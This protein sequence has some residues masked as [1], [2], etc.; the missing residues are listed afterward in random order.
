MPLISRCTYWMALRMRQVQAHSYFF[1]NN[2]TIRTLR[3]RGWVCLSDVWQYELTEEGYN[4]LCEWEQNKRDNYR[5][6]ALHNAIYLTGARNGTGCA[7]YYP[8]S[9]EKRAGEQVILDPYIVGRMIDDAE[10]VYSTADGYWY[11]EHSTDPGNRSWRVSYCD[12]SF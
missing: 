5:H 11:A 9:G 2:P 10:L 4:R 3:K 12:L 7:F 1:C 8:A 6:I